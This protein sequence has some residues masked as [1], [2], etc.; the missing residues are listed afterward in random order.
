MYV[1]FMIDIFIVF[2]N[3]KIK[4]IFLNKSKKKINTI[5]LKDSVKFLVFDIKFNENNKRKL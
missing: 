2:Y 4:K 5:I 3:N 1:C